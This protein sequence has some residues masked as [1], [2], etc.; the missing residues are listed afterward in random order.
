MLPKTADN[1]NHENK[2]QHFQPHL[3]I[4]HDQRR[5]QTSGKR[6]QCTGHDEGDGKQPVD[7]N[8]ETFDVLDILDASPDR[9]ADDSFVQEQPD[10][11]INE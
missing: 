6:R 8:A 4:D 11:E 7:V 9:L 2:S 3:R 1:H 5:M 10:A